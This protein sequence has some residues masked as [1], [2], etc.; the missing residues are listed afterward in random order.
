M[1]KKKGVCF[2]LVFWLSTLILL[3]LDQWSKQL[4]VVHL[5]GKSALSIIEN[6]FCLQ[7]LENQGAAFG[8]LQGK[9]FYFVVLTLIFFVAVIW[10]YFKIQTKKRYY[11]IYVIMSLFL[12]GAT[13]NFIDRISYNYVIDFFYFEI[14]HFPIFNVADIYV[15]CG[16]A[17]F[18]IFFLFYYK[19]KDLDELS[20][21]IFPRRK[22]N[23]E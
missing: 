4:A 9:K 13:G 2:H 15:T 17:L 7:Y 5:K 22:K 10:V 3:V 11:P 12:A 21:Q 14:I 18:L 6:I 19:E 8:I 23:K 16:A 1:M 20:G